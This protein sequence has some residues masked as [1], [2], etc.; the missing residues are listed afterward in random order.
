MSFTGEVSEFIKTLGP[1]FYEYVDESD[2]ESMTVKEKEDS[3]I[4]A[5]CKLDNEVLAI[6]NQKPTDDNYYSDDSSV[7]SGSVGT[8][9]LGQRRVSGS[10][11]EEYHDPL[12]E[13]KTSS[14]SSV[15]VT[16][17][18]KLQF[19]RMCVGT[20]TWLDPPSLEPSIAEGY[21]EAIKLLQEDLED[22]RTRLKVLE[23]TQRNSQSDYKVIIDLNNWS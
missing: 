5:D 3:G 20:R 6:L 7:H 23:D 19:P 18:Y 8:V 10:S 16:Y 15:L 13:V 17:P 21:K 14:F 1:T 12:T 11:A 2:D 9:Q 4:E 22:I